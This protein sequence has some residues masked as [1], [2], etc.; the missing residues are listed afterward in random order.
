MMNVGQLNV[1]E[2]NTFRNMN[3]SYPQSGRLSLE[4][5]LFQLPIDIQ[6]PE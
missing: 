1:E 3:T 5:N 2:A 4:N 6:P